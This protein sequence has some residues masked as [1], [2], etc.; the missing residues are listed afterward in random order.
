M[1]TKEELKALFK[2]GDV[3]G[4]EQFW[5]WMDSYWHK[6]EPIEAT[7]TLYSNPRPTQY[8]VGGVPLGV[9]VPKNP[10]A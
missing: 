6:E 9:S 1:T 7:S 10:T 2:N 5:T 8:E 3:P 4:Q